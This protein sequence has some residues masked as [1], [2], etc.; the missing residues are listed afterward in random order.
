MASIYHPH[1]ESQYRISNDQVT[2]LLKGAPPKAD[3]LL[4]QDINANIGI[5]YESSELSSIIG[6]HGFDNRNDKGVW[7][8]QL[9]ALQDL[10]VTNTFFEHRDHT[11]HTSYLPPS[12]PQMLDVISVS[13]SSFKRVRDCALW[14]H[15]IPSDHAGIICKFSITPISFK[16]SPSPCQQAKWIGKK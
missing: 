5:R 14:E 7:A 8:L 3:K 4:G 10:M 11:T 12:L 13:S 16:H 15:S 2:S 9:L 1:E 6:P